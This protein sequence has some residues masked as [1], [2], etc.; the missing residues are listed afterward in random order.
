MY[1]KVLCIWF[2]IINQSSPLSW[3]DHISNNERAI[4]GPRTG[5]SGGGLL[6]ATIGSVF[7]FKTCLPS[8]E[9]LISCFFGV[10]VATVPGYKSISLS[11]IKKELGKLNLYT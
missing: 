9:S 6:K 3:L 8:P 7:S 5:G 10:E 2:C 4:S 1:M 11:G